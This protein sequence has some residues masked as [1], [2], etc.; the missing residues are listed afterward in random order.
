MQ[1]VICPDG[2]DNKNYMRYTN[3][4]LWGFIQ[5]H[6]D[7]S[8]FSGTD[9]D[10]RDKNKENPAYSIDLNK[11][12]WYD[13]NAGKGGGLFELAKS[14]HVI[15]EKE[16]KKLKS[17][18][19][20]RKQTATTDS[21][22]K[23]RTTPTPNDIWQKANQDDDA[24]KR[25]FTQGRRIPENHYTD[26][27]RL[28][29]VD[30]YNGKHVIHP[31]FSIDSWQSELSG[32]PT[33]VPRIQR[34]WFDD[35]GEKMDKKHFGKTGAM[36]VCF[37][38]QPLDGNRESKKAVI[39][40]GIENALSIRAH[41]SDSWLF[42]ATCKSGLKL[43]PEF[44]KNFDDVLILS[45]HDYDSE[46]YPEKSKHPP[47][48]KTG[49]AEAWRLSETLIKQAYTLGKQNFS[50]RAVMPRQTGE[51]A[52][53]AL[54][55]AQLA[56]FIDDLINIPE[57]FRSCDESTGTSGGLVVLSLEELLRRPTPPR[58]NLLGPWLPEQGL[59]MIYA[60]R[61]LGKTWVA[62]QIAYAVS[63]GGEYLNWKAEKAAGVLYIDGEMPLAVMKE[64]LT[65][66]V[67]SQEMETKEPLDFLTPD[68][69]EFGVP[70]LSTIEGQALIDNIITDKTKLI[71]MDNL[72]TLTRSGKESE[73]E[74]WLPVQQWVL[75]LRRRGISVLFI[76]HAGKA[77]QQRGTSRREDVLDTVIV[78]RKPAD[79]T[80]ETGA[81]FEVHFE[82]ARGLYGDEIKPFEAS[83]ESHEDNNGTTTINWT[84]KNLDESTRE[85]VKNYL[86]DGW[87][88]K[89]IAEQLGI[90]KSSVNY[91]A[92]K[93]ENTGN[94]G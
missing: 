34:I 71:V 4:E 51:D 14:L 79:Y 66:I 5:Q 28:F 1:A 18:P 61:G 93:L 67:L 3:L 57:K 12:Q 78:L 59:C 40:E 50:C 75:K 29:R 35:N 77:G 23:K 53:D 70:D 80:P 45:D 83:L 81:C 68:A 22:P 56:E 43:L 30:H 42:V 52:N 94:F 41:Y 91:H 85:K 15:P 37:P 48:D 72:S 32:N 2:T 46:T 44:M 62:L 36:P 19:T 39:L 47:A 33:K 88:Q 49:Q 13:H 86:A 87:T 69:Q 31:Y 17:S 65:Q 6:S 7:F 20:A 8:N 84:V 74:S 16:N 11:G 38:I 63:S 73:G 82:K 21:T 54:R 64:R 10:L 90:N 60:T 76:H 92:K 27:F 25:Y 26:I 9:D 58:Q 89:D 55:A 24:V